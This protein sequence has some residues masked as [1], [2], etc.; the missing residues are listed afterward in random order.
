MSTPVI[1]APPGM[2]VPELHQL[3]LK[4]DIRRL[5]IVNPQDELLGII[6]HIDVINASPSPATSLSIWEINY[7]ISQ[8]QAQ[9]IMTRE[10]YTVKIND[11]IEKAA[12][13]MSDQKIGGVPVLSGEQVVGMIT[14]TDIFDLF[15]D[16]TGARDQG[17]RVSALIA[18]ARGEVAHLTRAISERG[19][20]L[21]ALGISHSGSAETGEIL[22][23]V[24]NLDEEVLLSV[25]RPRVI[26]ILDVRQT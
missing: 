1:T 12:R 15:M 26:R 22:L 24:N 8:I 6:S 18:D 14:E 25:I 20:D 23:K 3:M 7:L 13:I 17:I 9:E 21:I 11:T 19:G 2:T 4:R 5:P 16:L 10:V